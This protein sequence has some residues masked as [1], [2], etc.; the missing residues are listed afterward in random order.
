[1]PLGF[2]R[3]SPDRHI[4][5]NKDFILNA[6]DYL[7]DDNGVITARTKEFK[8]RPL[9]KVEIE[10]NKMVWQVLNLLGPLVFIVLLGGG[11][12]FWRQKQFS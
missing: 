7:L 12:Y 4:Y 2:D 10:E 6:V 11:W 8:L 9:D 3:F 1:M 5:A